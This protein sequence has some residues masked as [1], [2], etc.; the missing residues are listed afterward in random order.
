MSAFWFRFSELLGFYNYQ[1][2]NRM[3]FN[4][5]ENVFIS[6][7]RFEKKLSEKTIQFYQIDL[8]QFDLFLSSNQ[9]TREVQ[10]INKDLLR[11]YLQSISHFKPKTI[12]RKIATLKA[13]FN[14]LEFEDSI[15]V[16]PF[17]KLRVKIKDPRVLPTHMNN[18]EVK[19]I[20]QTAYTNLFG[21]E[22]DKPV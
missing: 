17:R 12:K 16:N 10:E 19:R 18:E 22:V 11:A 2:P 5:A 3:N 7:C 21:S 1:K 6:H 14:F 9:F 8:K 4:T 20:F 15:T 13:F